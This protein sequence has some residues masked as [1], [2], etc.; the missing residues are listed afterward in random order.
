MSDQ[1][2]QAPDQG[3][4]IQGE[5]PQYTATEQK[6]MEQGWMPLDKWTEAGR[7][8]SEHRS[9]REFQDRGELLKRIQDQN[10]TLHSMQ[11][12][13]ETLRRHNE[14]TYENAYKSALADLK[15][16]HAAAVNDGDIAKADALV[17]QI[18]DEKANFVQA[19]AAQAAAQQTQQIEAPEV[20]AW[21]EAN[22][23]YEDDEDLRVQ[24]D[25]F[26]F[27]YVQQ[28]GGKVTPDEILKHVSKK[29]EK[30]L[31]KPQG[32]P[33]DEPTRFTAPNPVGDSRGTRATVTGGSIKESQLTED[34]SKA[35][36]DF[37]KYGLGT[38]AD[39]LKQLSEIR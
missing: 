37:V 26:G 7:D 27:R 36:K 19:K 17:E 10:K 24:A 6:A 8:P 31:P 11:A 9:A 18:A 2:N 33:A 30:Y 29:M 34:E 28:K 15:A 20:T 35:M 16:K 32:Q 23:W 5:A 12:S 22:P 38:K 13:F 1:T 3:T 14:K 21:K 4:P 25:A 39:Y